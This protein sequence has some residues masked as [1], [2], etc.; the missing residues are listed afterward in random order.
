[1]DGSVGRMLAFDVKYMYIVT[2]TLSLLEVHPET[3]YVADALCYMALD[4]D[5]HR[6]RKCVRHSYSIERTRLKP[7]MTKF[8]N[9][10]VY[11][12][13]NPGHGLGKLPLELSGL[14]QH[15]TSASNFA[16]IA[17]TVINSKSSDILLYSGCFHS[18]VYLWLRYHY[19]GHLEVSVDGK[20]LV[21]LKLGA[22]YPEQTR[23]VVLMIRDTCKKKKGVHG[24]DTIKV[25][26]IMSGKM[27]LI[28]TALSLDGLKKPMSAFRRQ[29]YEVDEIR[30]SEARGSFNAREFME[31]RLVAQD[32]VAWMPSTRVTFD[33]AHDLGFSALFKGSDPSSM[34]I[35]VLLKN[36]PKMMLCN[37]GGLSRPK[38]VFIPPM[39]SDDGNDLRLSLDE[40]IRQCFPAMITLFD[41]VKLRCN[42]HGCAHDKP[43]GLGKTGCLRETAL[44]VIIILVGDAIADGFGARDASGLT[45]YK[46][47]MGSVHTLLLDLVVHKQVNWDTWFSLAAQVTTGYDWD[48]SNF[49]PSEGSTAI[50]AVQNGSMA[51]AAEWLNLATE[52]NYKAC[53]G[54]E[55]TEGRLSGVV[56]ECAI[57]QAEQEMDPPNSA[58]PEPMVLDDQTMSDPNALSTMTE[59]VKMNHGDTGAKLEMAITGAGGAPYRL[60]TMVKTSSNRRIVDPCQAIKAFLESEFPR[61]K[62]NCSQLHVKPEG[63]PETFE[64]AFNDA[65]GCWGKDNFFKEKRSRGDTLSLDNICWR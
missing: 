36:R 65:V 57:V 31:I 8:V 3:D 59:M 47:L 44:K 27:T 41:L 39:L 11:N 1:M 60:L 54:F 58:Q 5:C 18:D 15:T 7:V 46:L 26:S 34:T 21:D 17:M 49:V 30:E 10:I 14:C 42:C 37:W 25:C 40:V 55:V 63:Q 19:S 22:Y 9:S 13:A 38:M 29:F 48:A 64:W 28:F 12:V 20:I 51:V 32:L 50:V 23:R 24:E 52:I 16:A 6:A 35:E 61:C 4:K 56:D 53:F 43:L 45:N 2:T 62:P 33:S